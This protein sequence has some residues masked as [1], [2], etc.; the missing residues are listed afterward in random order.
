MCD[1]SARRGWRAFDKP[2]VGQGFTQLAAYPDVRL[3]FAPSI[4][5]QRAALRQK[6]AGF[7]P[8]C[9]TSRIRCRRFA[10]MRQCKYKYTTGIR[11]GL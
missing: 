11:I 1:R 3:W 5:L 7:E 2:Y 10:Q 8:Y 4:F 9:K 6:L